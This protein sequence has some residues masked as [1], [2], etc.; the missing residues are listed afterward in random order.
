MR[1]IFEEA[2]FL[3]DHD[4]NSIEAFVGF[5]GIPHTLKYGSGEALELHVREILSGKRSEHWIQACHGSEQAAAF[6]FPYALLTATGRF[7]RKGN[8]CLR[9]RPART[10]G[11][12]IIIRGDYSGGSI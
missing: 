1:T 7:P 11:A 10:A 9:I 2:F 3:R 12:Q 5:A 8:G 4:L 6:C